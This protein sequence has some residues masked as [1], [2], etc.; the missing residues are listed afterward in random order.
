[1]RN[2][3][4]LKP[5]F[6]RIIFTSLKPTYEEWKQFPGPVGEPVV[7]G[8]KPT[9]KEWKLKKDERI[10][11]VIFKKYLII[12]DDDSEGERLGGHGSTGV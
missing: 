12:D 3:N 10:G 2:G 4:Q 8:L 11:Q 1:M 9:Y 7:L 5:S 6:R